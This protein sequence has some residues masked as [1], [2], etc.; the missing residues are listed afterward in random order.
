MARYGRRTRLSGGGSGSVCSELN[1]RLRAKVGEVP[2]AAAAWSIAAAR[3]KTNGRG[4]SRGPGGT[5]PCGT[6]GAAPAPSR[7]CRRWRPS[8]RSACWRA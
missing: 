3:A 1:M 8:R 2:R 6:C 7:R 5:V 4:S